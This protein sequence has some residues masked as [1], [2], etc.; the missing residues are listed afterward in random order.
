MKETKDVLIIVDMLND[1]VDTKGALAF[2]AAL[3]IV[4]VIKKK[5]E[6][7]R[8]DNKPIIFLCDSHDENDLE[9]ERFP[10]HAIKDTW[11]SE[12]VLELEPK[13]L[14]AHVTEH[15]IRKTRYSGFFNTRLGNTLIHIE[16]KTVEICGVCTSICVMDTVGGLANRDYE[17]FIDV[18]AVAD[19]DDKA[20]DSA[21]KRMESLYGAYNDGKELREKD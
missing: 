13:K 16:A 19:F 8:K 6:Q 7:Y 9:F 1:F 12:V 17:T 21:L 11:G 15:I 10:K 4:L 3:D 5:L 18:D 14:Q 2:P 20:H